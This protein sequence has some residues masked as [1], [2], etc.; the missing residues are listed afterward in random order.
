MSWPYHLIRSQLDQTKKERVAYQQLLEEA[1][2]QEQ[3]LLW[4]SICQFFEHCCLARIVAG[5]DF[6]VFRNG[7]YG[8]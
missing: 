2:R 6:Q 1:R 4:E 8:E 5:V 7:N 3:A